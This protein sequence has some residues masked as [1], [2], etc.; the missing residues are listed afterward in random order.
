MHLASAHKKCPAQKVGHPGL[1][2]PI[3]HICSLTN[4]ISPVGA[5][6]FAIQDTKIQYRNYL[7]INNNS[8]YCYAVIYLSGSEFRGHI[9]GNFSF[10]NNFGSLLAAADSNMSFSGYAEFVN[11]QPSIRTCTGT[12]QEGGVITL[13][14]SSVVFLWRMQS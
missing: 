12:F 7:L 4:N 9:S 11:N 1:L 14:Q 10:L 13:F 5:V 6:V 8:A 2:Y 3:P